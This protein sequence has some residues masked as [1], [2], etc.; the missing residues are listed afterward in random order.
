VAQRV[1]HRV[2]VHARSQG[3]EQAP[4][5]VDN[6]I[7]RLRE[8][9]IKLPPTTTTPYLNTI[10]A[11]KEPAYPGDWQIE[12]RIKSLIRWNAMAMVVNANRKYNGLGGHIS[13]YA[14]CATLYEVA[15]NHFFRGGD[16]GSN[17]NSMG[18]KDFAPTQLMSFGSCEPFPDLPRLTFG[19]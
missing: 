7:D 4:Y 13:T 3:A 10:P 6:L 11:E 15:Y 12:T 5:F 18:L 19:C 17:G 9:G 1:G 14:S 16:D 2:Q 8:A